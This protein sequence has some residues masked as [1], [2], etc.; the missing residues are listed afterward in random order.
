MSELGEQQAAFAGTYFREYFEKNQL[1]FDKIVIDC[2]PFMRCIQ[3]ANG[4]A[5][6]LGVK[7]ININ[8]LYVEHFRP[9]DYKLDDPVLH[10]MVNSMDDC[11]DA[12]FKKKY[13]LSPDITFTDSKH[14]RDEIATAWP[15]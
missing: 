8:H 6:G 14:Y 7:E 10:I 13:G 9:M 15:E 12:E 2:S 5:E 1:Q 11:N 4:I 3:T